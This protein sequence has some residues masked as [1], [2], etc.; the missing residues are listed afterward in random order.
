LGSI[1]VCISVERGNFEDGE[2]KSMPSTD[3]AKDNYFYVFDIDLRIQVKCLPLA[4]LA[5]T[6][7]AER[8]L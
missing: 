3:E 2:Y 8:S 5:E 1:I 4:H 6:F 7:E